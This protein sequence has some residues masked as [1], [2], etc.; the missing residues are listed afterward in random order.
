MPFLNPPLSIA[1]RVNDVFLYIFILSVAFLVFITALMVYFVIKY[2]RKRNP[3]PVD[4]EGNMPLE[5]TWTVI[6]LI[7]FL[8]MFYFGWTNF[9][10][11]RNPPRDAM[12]IDVTARQWA[13]SFQYPNG[14]RSDEL[15][16]ALNRPVKLDLHSL[17][18]LHGFYIAAF[19]IKEDVVP[20]RTNYTWFQPTLLGT[21][22]IQCTVMCGLQHSYMLSKVH[23]LPV[24]EFKEWY[25]ATENGP[26]PAKPQPAAVQ[27]AAAVAAAGEPGL[28]V[29]QQKNCLV[30]HSVDGSEK[31]GVSLKGL[32]GK[33]QTVVAGGKEQQVTVD[34][35]YLANTL[36]EPHTHLVK[37]Y[38]PAMPVP[39]L[40]D[41]EIGQ[42]IAY[43]R[44]LK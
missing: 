27:P 3:T 23:V 15:Y 18:V 44:E 41:D 19:R 21:F 22:D 16:V 8:T 14:K 7:L 32:Y 6:P 25:F 26:P 1:D 30:C 28:A 29:L 9:S 20:G 39:S 11:M 4:I 10:Y 40:N 38:P 36:R 5:I 17:D 33:Q 35:F 43:I 2:N 37:G 13:W 31:V 34:E 24:E 42:V 12:V